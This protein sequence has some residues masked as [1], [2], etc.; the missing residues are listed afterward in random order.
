MSNS[1]L[2]NTQSRWLSS[3]N[4]VVKGPKSLQ[5]LLQVQ[6]NYSTLGQVDVWDYAKAYNNVHMNKKKLHMRKL[7]GKDSKDEH[8]AL[9]GQATRFWLRSH[10]GTRAR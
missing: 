5:P 7:A 9:W 2:G 1:S 4:F 3:N 10:Q 6:A 8:Y